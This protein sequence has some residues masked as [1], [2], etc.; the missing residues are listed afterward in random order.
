MLDKALL[1]K[2]ESARGKWFISLY[3]E[4]LDDCLPSYSYQSNGCGGFIG[5]VAPEV[6]MQYA[7][8]QAS[9]CP[10]KMRRTIFNQTLA[11]KCCALWQK[12][13]AL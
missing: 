2:W 1:A 8:Q 11:E 4:T 6:A 5:T 7:S 12:G 3:A 9:Y 10:A 13:G